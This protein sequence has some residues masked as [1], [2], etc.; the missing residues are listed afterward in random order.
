MD[1]SLPT[2]LLKD[3]PALDKFIDESCAYTKMLGSIES[4][5]VFD[6]ENDA[7]E[8]YDWL[9][10]LRLRVK[11]TD[12]Y[13][14]YKVVYRDSKEFG[15]HAELCYVPNYLDAAI[16]FEAN[17]IVI[18]PCQY[19]FAAGM[20]DIKINS[21]VNELYFD[22][23]AAQSIKILMRINIEKVLIQTNERYTI[24]NLS[25][26][27]ISKTVKRVYCNRPLILR[28]GYPLDDIGMYVMITESGIF[29]I[30]G[31][32]TK[33]I[34]DDQLIDKILSSIVKYHTEGTGLIYNVNESF[35]FSDI[36]RGQ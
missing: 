18:V 8:G 33:K 22:A 20:G 2:S 1:I 21:N 27:T 3:K 24:Y 23:D 17:R 34:T 11:I 9:N 28:A 36:L 30:R 25:K 31:N 7:G 10:G 4:E 19:D 35:N 12:G 15:V 6:L 5:T 26:S 14:T 29:D 32:K 13:R 16:N